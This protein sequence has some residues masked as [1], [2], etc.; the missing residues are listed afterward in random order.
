MAN[1]V[2]G[3]PTRALQSLALWECG[4]SF[5]DRGGTVFGYR[6]LWRK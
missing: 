6:D 5:S 2:A 1:E 3:G 4:A